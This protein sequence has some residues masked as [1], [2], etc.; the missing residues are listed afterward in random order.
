MNFIGLFC[1][2]HSIRD[3]EVG[4]ICKALYDFCFVTF[5]NLPNK[6]KSQNMYHFRGGTRCQIVGGQIDLNCGHFWL[7]SK[8]CW[9]L[10]KYLLVLWK[11][12]WAWASFLNLFTQPCN[13]NVSEYKRKS[14]AYVTLSPCSTDSKMV[15]VKGRSW[16]KICFIKWIAHFFSVRALKTYHL[17]VSWAWKS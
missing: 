6:N 14:W 9:A 1:Y 16:K 7:S 3:K 13:G 8:S 4:L 15:V 11:H 5:K 12:E 17:C 2:G 10:C